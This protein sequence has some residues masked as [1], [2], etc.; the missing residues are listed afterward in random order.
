MDATLIQLAHDTKDFLVPM[1]PYL[2]P[3]AAGA[4]KAAL[5]RTGEKISDITWNKAEALWNMLWPKIEKRPTAL[6][7]AQ[8]LA[9]TP[10]DMDAQGAFS[11]QL[12]KLFAADPDLAKT[13]TQFFLDSSVNITASGERS[14]ATNTVTNSVINTGDY[15]EG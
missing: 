6:E 7:A 5:K 12:K 1:L 9:N 14:V 10:D 13:V 8:V 15:K 11:T 3:A 4:G 2:L